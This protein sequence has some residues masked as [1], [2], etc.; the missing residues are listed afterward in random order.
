MHFL[1][2]I[3][4]TTLILYIL[5]KNFNSKRCK[6]FLVRVVDDTKGKKQLLLL[7]RISS[8]ETTVF[9]QAHVHAFYIYAHIY[10]TYALSAVYPWQ[11]IKIEIGIENWSFRISCTSYLQIMSNIWLN[12]CNLLIDC[13][14]SLNRIIKVIPDV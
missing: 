7:D 2:L 5:F 8:W 12:K 11:A 1:Y 3:K 6:I 4:L 10:L 14:L 13:F 9:F